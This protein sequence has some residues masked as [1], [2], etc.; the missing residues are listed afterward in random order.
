MASPC[1]VA[2][3]SGPWEYQATLHRL[4]STTDAPTRTHDLVTTLSS[5]YF[6][7]MRHPRHRFGAALGV[8]FVLALGAACS[9][10][11]T[12]TE[13]IVT[14]NCPASGAA[15]GNEMTVLGC[16]NFKPLRTTGEI[17]VRGN[18]A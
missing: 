5:W 17:F 16:G 3:R 2:R 14:A 7:R 11:D 4:I 9:A 12:S 6:A 18:T 10:D 1:P 8:L 15:S 13:P